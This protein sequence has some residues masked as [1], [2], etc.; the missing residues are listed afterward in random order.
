MIKIGRK[1][2]IVTILRE[3]KYNEMFT[4][5]LYRI[6]EFIAVSDYPDK[7]DPNVILKINENVVKLTKEDFSDYFDE[8]DLDEQFMMYLYE[9]IITAST[10]KKINR[11]IKKLLDSPKKCSEEDIMAISNWESSNHSV[12]CTLRGIASGEIVLH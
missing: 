12:Y 5:D 7:I 4:T 11:I 6:K 2:N 1:P 8:L 3:E 10:H 9:N